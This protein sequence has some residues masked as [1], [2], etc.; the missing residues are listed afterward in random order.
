MLI[1][2]FRDTQIRQNGKSIKTIILSKSQKYEN[3]SGCN[4][5][6]IGNRY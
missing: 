4:G 3:L 1:G 2:N 6:R 5:Y